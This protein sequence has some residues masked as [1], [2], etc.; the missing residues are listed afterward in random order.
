MVG[1]PGPVAIRFESEF[2]HGPDHRNSN[3][4]DRKHHNLPS[5]GFGYAST[6]R[7]GPIAAHGRIRRLDRNYYVAACG[8][9]R[10]TLF[11]HTD[12]YGRHSAIQLV[13]VRRFLAARLVLE[14]R[15]RSHQRYAHA[16]RCQ[17]P[18]R[19]QRHRRRNATAGSE[20][21]PANDHDQRA[22]VD[23]DN[24][25]G[26]WHGGGGLQCDGGSKWGNRTL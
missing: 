23:H 14:R 20:P 24:I 22:A 2:G 4:C 7:N 17:S 16:R 3:D 8:P 15:H 19:V 13:F 21:K 10:C 25:A 26:K 12:S 11:R 5:D 18:A 1:S 6:D 9:S